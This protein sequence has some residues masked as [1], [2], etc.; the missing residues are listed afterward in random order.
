MQWNGAAETSLP[1]E[2]S[3]AAPTAHPEP[4]PTVPRRTAWVLG[5]LGLLPFV[6][7]AA[8]LAWAGRDFI[9]YERLFIAFAGY[10][11]TILAFLGGI[12][13][14]LA[15]TPGHHR[16]R[17]LVLSVVPSL[18]GWL[19]LFVPAPWSFAGFALAFALQG[20]W[21]RLAARG[22]SFPSWFAQLRTVL[23]V[24]VVL[25]EL[26]AFAATY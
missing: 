17:I 1:A 16:R 3:A 12:R 15:L 2:P 11:A 26:V 13:W 20:L 22:R 18:F 14:G 6:L 5:L 21:D 8:V 24:V 19:L 4:V 25:C 9:A 7:L 23:T 10:S